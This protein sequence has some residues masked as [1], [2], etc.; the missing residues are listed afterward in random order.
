VI[1]FAIPGSLFVLA[2]GITLHALWCDFGVRS[3][4]LLFFAINAFYLSWRD[5]QQLR[6]RISWR[7]RSLFFADTYF[8]TLRPDGWLGRHIAG[9]VGSMMANLSVLVLTLLPLSLH[10]L[11]PAILFIAGAVIA[12]KERTKKMRTRVTMPPLVRMPRNPATGEQKEDSV[13]R[14]AA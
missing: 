2:C 8:R 11:W 12:H 1:D 13:T 5:A 14:R 4:Y 6:D 9:M 10:W 7:R 3:F